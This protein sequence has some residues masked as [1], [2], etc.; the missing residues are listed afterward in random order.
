MKEIRRLKREN[1]IFEKKNSELEIEN[2]KMLRD[3]EKEHDVFASQIEKLKHQ[4]EYLEKD[5]PPSG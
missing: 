3:W 4:I 2:K 5:Y 1:Q